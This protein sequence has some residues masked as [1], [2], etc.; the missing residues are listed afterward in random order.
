MKKILII[1]LNSILL[2]LILEAVFKTIDLISSS[3][4]DNKKNIISYYSEYKKHPFLGYTARKNSSGFDIHYVPNTFFR[5]STN[6]DGFRTKEFYPKKSNI[7]RILL[8]GDSFVFG[9]NVHDD[10]TLSIQLEKKLKKKYS[11]IEVLSLGIIGYSGL[12]YAGLAK[13][14]FKYLDPDLII[15]CVDQS[16]FQDDINK[17]EIYKYKFDKNGFPLYIDKFPSQNS[18]FIDNQRNII[19][20][21]KKKKTI[22]HKLKLESSLFKRLNKIRHILKKNKLESE[23]K[24]LIS[25]KYE[26]INYSN[27]N[28]K[29]KNDLSLIVKS[30]DILPYS[31]EKSLKNYQL[32]IKSLEYIKLKSDEIN[33]KIF[34]STYPYGWFVNKNNSKY[35]QLKNFGKILDFTSNTVYPDLVNEISKKLEIQNLDSYSY[36]KKLNGDYWGI[37]DPHFN[38]DGY[39]KYSEYLLIQLDKYIENNIKK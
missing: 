17:N 21:D 13:T 39:E 34:F 36:F 23:Y 18:F 19:L 22:V 16:D 37:Y 15:V 24:K 32:T 11:D 26:T 7:F 38:K 25:A 27:L 2:I 5:T 29:E 14:Y 20:S 35:Y 30:G 9:Q 4:F 6:S 3:Y 12:N 10:E 33:S 8:I 28:N 31:V 1:L